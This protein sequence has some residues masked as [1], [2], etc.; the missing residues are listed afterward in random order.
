MSSKSVW[1]GEQADRKGVTGV[2]LES[3][4]SEIEPHPDEIPPTRDSVQEVKEVKA[5]PGSFSALLLG[6]KRSR[7][8]TSFSELVN[9]QPKEEQPRKFNSTAGT[10]LQGDSWKPDTKAQLEL[11]DNFDILEAAEDIAERR[12]AGPVNY[13]GLM[14]Q[15]KEKNLI[16]DH[17]VADLGQVREQVTAK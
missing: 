16:C 15:G 3:E 13:I 4:N 2:S 1:K 5:E 8:P 9:P 7:S 14:Q 10:Y 17:Q 12:K 6:E 11:A